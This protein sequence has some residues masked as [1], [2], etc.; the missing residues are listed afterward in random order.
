[1]SLVAADYTEHRWH[2][3]QKHSLLEALPK[4][5]RAQSGGTL[6]N[7]PKKKDTIKIMEKK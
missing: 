4:L 3:L 7:G 1:M 6:E 2:Y 5:I